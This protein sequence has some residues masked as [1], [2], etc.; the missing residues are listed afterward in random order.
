MK[1]ENCPCEKLV[2]RKVTELI[3]LAGQIVKVVDAPARVCLDCG[4]IHFE[5][6]FIL[7]LEEKLLKQQ[8]QAA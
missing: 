5:G 7:D 3:P 6:R 8:K 1:R 2:K 4:E